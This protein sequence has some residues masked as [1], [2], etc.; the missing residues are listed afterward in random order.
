M[1]LSATLFVTA[2]AI[3]APALAG[4]KHA[5]NA[6]RPA[7]AM[8]TVDI[9]EVVNPTDTLGEAKVEDA[10]GANIGQVQRVVTSDTGLVGRV[11]VSLTQPQKVVALTPEQLRYVP[12]NGKLRTTMTADQVVT[13][14]AAKGQ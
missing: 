8:K 12:F 5:A 4:D 2:M 7:S 6:P 3:A 13:L 10:K 11:E 9:S 1:R 14:P